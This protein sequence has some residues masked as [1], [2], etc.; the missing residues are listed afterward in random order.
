M[1]EDMGARQ[2]ELVLVG[3]IL[4]VEGIVE[5]RPSALFDVGAE[6]VRDGPRADELDEP[7]HAVGVGVDLAVRHVQATGVQTVAAQEVARFSI[8]E[9]DAGRVVAGNRDEVHDALSQVDTSGRRG[10]CRDASGFLDRRGRSGDELYVRQRLELIVS[11]R[12]IA[13]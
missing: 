3:L 8:V 5:V 12:V 4:R 11:C 1:L 9:C 2:C 7:L 10:P 6:H 13:M